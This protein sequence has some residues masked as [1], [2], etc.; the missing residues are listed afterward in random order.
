[1]DDEV[2][3]KYPK[4]KD[5]FPCLLKLPDLECDYK[6]PWHGK[7]ATKPILNE[8]KPLCKKAAS[9]GAI[10]LD[11]PEKPD[12]PEM[13]GGGGDSGGKGDSDGKGPG[14]EPPEMKG[15]PPAPPLNFA[16]LFPDVA[17]E[18]TPPCVSESCETPPEPAP[19]P[20]GPTMYYS[21]ASYAGDEDGVL[22][23]QFTR[24]V[25]SKT[26]EGRIKGADPRSEDY[27]LK[28][29]LLKRS[30]LNEGWA[31]GVEPSLIEKGYKLERKMKGAHFGADEGLKE[32][33]AGG[34]DPSLKDGWGGG[35]EPSMKDGW[36]GK[37]EPPKKEASSLNGSSFRGQGFAQSLPV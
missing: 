29:H 2:L 11:P 32:G 22:N 14:M 18:E 16:W 5:E 21:G 25:Q 12:P 6:L 13:G 3:P 7:N 26:I 1:L 10:K 23:D 36:G 8:V 4:D 28:D 27:F 31:G 15:P 33:W 17:V 34:E 37:V 24:H 20:S 19:V 35:E 30:F 9:L